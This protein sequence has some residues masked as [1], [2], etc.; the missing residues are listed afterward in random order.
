MGA[1]MADQRPR[2]QS[3]KFYIL[4]FSGACTQDRLSANPIS[5]VKDPTKKIHRDR[6]LGMQELRAVW[7]AASVLG[8]P[9]GPMYRLLLLTACRRGEWA[10]SRRAWLSIDESLMLIPS[11]AY[12]SGTAQVVSLVNPALEIVEALP[13][14]NA[15]DY[16]FS[17]TG[18]ERPV[19]GFTRAKIRL[20]KAVANEL[21]HPLDDWRP[22]DF[23]RSVATHL[24]RLGTDRHV[25][26]RILGHADHDVT[27]IY[28]RYSLLPE[29][30]AALELLVPRT[31][32]MIEISEATLDYILEPLWDTVS[33]HRRE[34]AAFRNDL[35]E[36]LA[37]A[38]DAHQMADHETSISDKRSVETATAAM[39][40]ALHHVADKRL[41]RRIYEVN[42]EHNDVVTNVETNNEIAAYEVWWELARPAKE[43]E[44]LLAEAE[45]AICDAIEILS[46]S[47]VEISKPQ[48]NDAKRVSWMLPGRIMVQFLERIGAP[49][50]ASRKGSLPNDTADFISRSL[51]AI[52]ISVSAH[53]IAKLH[54]E[55]LP[56]IA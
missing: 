50:K 23:R 54:P 3:G 30:R 49:T 15:G 17:G 47:M 5:G 18:G 55:R 24:R 33:R 37:W 45:K 11:E 32:A 10:N 4:C 36:H 22:H 16:L 48:F 29:C 39:K 53:T 44:R 6:V 1:T 35:R 21:G 42:M 34:A 41:R 9:Y 14:W 27:S 13:H 51:Q 8:Y 31:P 26:K 52:G 19:S 12:K 7:R 2:G 43:A 38:Y 25:V 56:R 20:D 40:K 46:K 28:D